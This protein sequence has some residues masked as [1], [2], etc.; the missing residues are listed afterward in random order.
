MPISRVEEINRVE[1]LSAYRDA[2][3]ALLWRTSGASFFHTL[4]WLEAY[5]KHYGADQ[6]LRVLVRLDGQRV[7]GIVPLVVR[8]ES[9]RAGQI[10]VLTYPLHDWGSFYGP[11]GPEP[12]DTLTAAL[13]HI[14]RTRR[15]WDLI[16]LRWIDA[17]SP[18][19]IETQRAM[20]AAGLQARQTL[21]DQTAVI[22]C[23]GT[24]QAYLAERN[25][26]WR[27]NLMR[28]RRRIEEAGGLDY[29]RYRP[30]PASGQAASAAFDPRWDLYEACE[31]I[32]AASW[33]GDSNTG[34][35]LSHETVR[36]FLRDCHGEAARLGMVDLNLLRL[37]GQPVAFAY[38][39]V[40]AQRVFGLRLG[41][42]R[43]RAQDGVGSLL[44]AQVVEDSFA[45]GDRLYDL[46]TGYL[47]TKRH[48]MTR[49]VNLLRYSHF[50][51]GACRAQLVHLKRWVQEQLFRNSTRRRELQARSGSAR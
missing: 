21:W 38:N 18:A 8:R 5:W 23:V 49:T 22:D 29:E 27:S 19:A 20:Q 44:L 40:C 9:T 16:E 17:G 13:E 25:A 51:P 10:R 43:A 32:A 45:R 37:H 36:Q 39:Y 42:D 48:F 15:D 2:W 12:L 3:D 31:Q 7:K 24:W 14:R 35:T 46:G 50:Y 11:I 30:E 28:S 1:E 41:Y 26:K 34:T 33:Q 4:A 6:K 47:D